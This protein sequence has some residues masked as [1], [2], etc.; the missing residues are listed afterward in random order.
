LLKGLWQAVSWFAESPSGAGKARAADGWA[1]AGLPVC[2]I[3]N[4]FAL[5]AEVGQDGAE[6]IR[7]A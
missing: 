5:G 7:T 3:K 4:K 1:G 2:R 6:N